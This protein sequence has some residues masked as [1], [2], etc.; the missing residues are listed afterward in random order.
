MKKHD[1]GALVISPTRELALQI[2]EVLEQFLKH[3][4]HLTHMSMIGGLKST[5]EDVK[6]Y[7]ENGAHIIISTPG[8]FMEILTRQSEKTNLAGGL[9]SLVTTPLIITKKE[10]I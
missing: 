1:V 4:P 6:A 8:R 3:V 5:H 9:K 2:Y 10:K 7:S